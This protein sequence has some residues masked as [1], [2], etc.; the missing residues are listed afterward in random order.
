M[1]LKLQILEI[2]EKEQREKYTVGSL[3][4]H[5]PKGTAIQAVLT[6]I[7]ELIAE[8]LVELKHEGQLYF[9]PTKNNDSK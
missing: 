9:T 8:E 4:Y 1:S 7:E 6:S 3:L 2:F 5:L